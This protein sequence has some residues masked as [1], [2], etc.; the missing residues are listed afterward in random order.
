MRPSALCPD[1]LDQTPHAFYKNLPNCLRIEI[2]LLNV[3]VNLP[4]VA[5]MPFR[6]HSFISSLGGGKTS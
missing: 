4:Q 5:E 3:H 1:D 2:I 6:R